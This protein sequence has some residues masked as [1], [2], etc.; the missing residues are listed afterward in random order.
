MD[1]NYWK[2]GTGKT[3]LLESI[4]QLIKYKGIMTYQNQELRKIKDASQHMY[5]VYQNQNY[6][7]L[8]IQ[9][10]KKFLFIIII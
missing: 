7:L 9:Y 3:S 6:N 1:Y 5:L 8:L 4:L 10:M 2:N